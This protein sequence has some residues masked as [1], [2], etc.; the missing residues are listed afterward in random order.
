MAAIF[1][2]VS[3]LVRFYVFNGEAESG[4]VFNIYTVVN[5]VIVYVYNV[6]MLQVYI[7]LSRFVYLQSQSFDSLK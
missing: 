6:S 4:S 3:F 2:F 5:M 7:V 1:Y